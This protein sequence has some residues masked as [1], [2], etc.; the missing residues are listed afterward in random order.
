M[1]AIGKPERARQKNTFTAWQSVDAFFLGPITKHKA[2]L[3]Q[4]AFNCVDCPANPF[5][6]SWQE[7][8]Q[9]H[10]EQTRIQ[11]IG[12]VNLGKSFLPRVITALAYFGVNLIANFLPPIDVSIPGTA[13]FF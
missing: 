8:S 13:T 6:S 9:W 3:H 1:Q 10:H 2:V 5:V 11:C 4:L 7:A 12:A